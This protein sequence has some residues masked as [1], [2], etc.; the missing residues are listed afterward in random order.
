MDKWEGKMLIANE[1]SNASIIEL[2]YYRLHLRTG[3]KERDT[4]R[5]CIDDGPDLLKRAYQALARQINKWNGQLQ[6]K[7]WIDY[8][9]PKEDQD[10]P[11]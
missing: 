10:A 5:I 8:A 6:W 1:T 3:F 9:I 7:F 2:A 11:G 4:I